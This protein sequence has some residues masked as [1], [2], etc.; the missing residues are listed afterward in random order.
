MLR[1][2]YLTPWHR[3][4]LYTIILAGEQQDETEPFMHS[5][6]LAYTLC[7]ILINGLRRRGLLG[8]R[9]NDMYY[10]QKLVPL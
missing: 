9:I 4:R 2:R 8:T 1:L 7:D 5:T 10:M 3:V 6:V